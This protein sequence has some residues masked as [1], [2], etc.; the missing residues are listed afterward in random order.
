MK[1]CD[2][3]RRAT[4]TYAQETKLVRI[5][6]D[7]IGPDY[8]NCIQRVLDMVKVQ[9]MI[10]SSQ[11]DGIL[12]INSVPDSHE[13]SFSDD[14]LPS[15]KLLQASLI[16]E[17]RQ[18]LKTKDELEQ[19]KPPKEKLPVA[20]GNF[21]EVQCY[22]CGGPHKKG[23]PSCRAAP[24]DVHSCAPAE[25]K[26]KQEEK[27]RKYGGKGSGGN[28][29]PKKQRTGE[30]KN[31]KFFNFGKGTC[32]NGAKCSFSHDRS[33]S[34]SKPAGK[35]K[36]GFDKKQKKSMASMVAA[37]FKKCTSKIAKEIK[38]KNKKLKGNRSRKDESGSESDEDNFSNMMARMFVCP[39]LNTIP[40]D[41]VKPKTLV[42]SSNLHNVDKNCGIDT[43]AG[44]SISTLRGDFPCGIDD[45][46]STINDLPSP[47]GIN[48]G[49]SRIGGI[50]PMVIMAKTG[51]LVIDPAG[52]YL[53]P[54]K[55]QP[56]FR[57]MAAQ[58]LKSNGVRL[59]GCFKNTDDDVL[60]DRVTKYTITLSEEGLI[61]KKILVLET[62]PCPV[63]T[64]R[65]RMNKLIDQI[66]KKNRSAL[67]PRHDS[68]FKDMDNRIREDAATKVLMSG[69]EERKFGTM[70]F[71]EA[72]VSVEERSRLYVRRLVIL[73]MGSYLS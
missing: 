37:E 29:Q 54:G 24:F 52:L 23:D 5:V 66:R 45:R 72:S 48:G 36:G 40:R 4:Y 56:N 9:K 49:Q 28:S 69:N 30:K 47:S 21:G 14:W 32:R 35:G 63:F 17:Y 55:D 10:Q 18:K 31:C 25:F 16:S 41:P 6:I 73:I 39:V 34:S 57:V 7:H 12:D 59:V 20:V 51:E 3:S 64:N 58:R 44:M 8:K 62:V 1:M 2:V 19:K 42:L 27:K 15:W 46:E 22:A 50:G 33:E 38:E 71:N 53:V 13:R 70:F 11:G 67:I 60:Q 43:D 68:V 65:L 26:A 61:N